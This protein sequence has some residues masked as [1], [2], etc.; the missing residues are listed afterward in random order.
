MQHVGFR[1]TFPY[2]LS[3]SYSTLTFE[4]ANTAFYLI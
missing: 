2:R 4:T 3:L 1:V